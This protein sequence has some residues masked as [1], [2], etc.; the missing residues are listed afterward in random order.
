MTATS[1]TTQ[2]DIVASVVDETASPAFSSTCLSNTNNVNLVWNINTVTSNVVAP[3]NIVGNFTFPGASSD[4]GYVPASI[5]LFFVNGSNAVPLSAVATSTTFSV[6]GINNWGSIANSSSAT[7][8]TGLWRGFTSSD[9]FDGNNWC[10]GSAPSIANDITVSNAVF[11]PIITT[12][13]AS[14]NSI[15]VNAGAYLSI[16]GTNANAIDVN[17]NIV[18][19]GTFGGIGAIINLLA[20]A[21][22][23][24]SGSGVMSAFRVRISNAGIKEILA[25]III[26]GLLKLDAGNTTLNSNGN[27]SLLSTSLTTAK[28]GVIPSTSSILGIVN[29]QRFVPSKIVRRNISSPV[30]NA[31]FNQLKR[32]I[33]LTG[34]GTGFEAPTFIPSVLMYDETNTAVSINVGKLQPTNSTDLLQVGRGYEVL[35]KDRNVNP[36]ETRPNQPSSPLLLSFSGIVNQGD[37]NLPVSYTNTS[38]ITADG[39]NLVGN[40]YP[41]EIDWDNGGWTKTNISNAVYLFDPGTSLTSTTTA[42]GQYYTYSGGSCVP[43]VAGCNSLIAMAQGFYVKAT[44]ANPVLSINENAKTDATHRANFRTEILEDKIGIVVDGNGFMDETLFKLDSNST[45][46][47]NSES[48]LFKFSNPTLNLSS[49]SDEGYNLVINKVG[50]SSQEVEFPIEFTSSQNG[51]YSF[52]ANKSIVNQPVDVFLKDKLL[53]TIEPISGSESYSFTHNTTNSGARFS[54]VFRKGEIEETTKIEENVEKILSVF[55]NP[56]TNGILYINLKSKN[57]ENVNFDLIGLSDGRII[58]TEAISIGGQNSTYEFNLN[59][60]SI[61]SGVYLLRARNQSMN[62]IFKIII[63]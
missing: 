25:P 10:G 54:V 35:I 7:S 31:D 48:D 2:G 49:K 4:I 18:N 59:Q 26:S 17:Q 22:M 43:A 52:T 55:P 44:G 16:T 12:T 50:L 58:H 39:W 60:L 61:S 9:W 19:N 3:I 34:S 11:M 24:I 32:T 5:S 41:S 27:I 47:F 63:Y 57:T 1:V 36:A 51:I 14:V 8:V 29:V 23:S 28:I 38:T 46:A 42:R 45:N 30:S 53:N 13:S 6:S 40:P 37:I 33:R 21:N 62:Q 20:P 56:V 15:T